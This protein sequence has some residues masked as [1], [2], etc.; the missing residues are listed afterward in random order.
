MVKGIASIAFYNPGARFLKTLTR[1]SRDLMTIA[2]DFRHLADQYSIVSFWEED[3]STR[4]GFRAVVSSTNFLSAIGGLFF[5][6]FRNTLHSWVFHAKSR[7][8]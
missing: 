3:I 7:A 8:R 2:E 4:G 1:N 6:S 5:R